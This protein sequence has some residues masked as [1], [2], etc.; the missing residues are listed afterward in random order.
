MNAQRSKTKMA[1]NEELDLQHDHEGFYCGYCSQCGTQIEREYIFCPQCGVNIERG[2]LSHTLTL[3]NHSLS[4]REIIESYFYSGFEYESILQFLS[5]FHAIKMSM[6]TL[7]RRLKNV[8]FAKKSSGSK[9]ERGNGN[10]EERVKPIWL[11]IRLSD[12]VAYI[13]H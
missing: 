6:S 8:R 3:G 13:T 10:Y 2:Y 4:E 7:K 1:E 12:D 9:Y 5:K 11:S